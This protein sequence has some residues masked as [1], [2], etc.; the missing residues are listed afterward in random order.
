ML[1][2]G[3]K[4]FAKEVL[5]IFYQQNKVDAVAFYDGVNDD[6]GDFIYN[7]FPI[8]KNDN[9]V[10][11]FF[12]EN[13]TQFT[14]GL[15]N[16]KSRYQL[17][18]KFVSLGGEYASSISPLAVIG[19]YDNKIEEGV[20]I[21]TNTILTN[22]IKIGKGVLINLSCTIG[23]DTKI[24]DFV[25]ICP[26][27]NISGN[28]FIDKFT[29]IGTNVTI[30]PNVKIGKNVTIGAGAVVTKN[31]PDNSIAMGIPAKVVKMHKQT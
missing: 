28:C 10:K 6:I 19:N 2:I 20:N 16:P 30:L 18:R 12:N 21:M 3:A 14:I 24:E 29:F 5:E 13:G 7:I 8:L 25:E 27:V 17:Y 23:H 31:I 22:S 4:G 26:G 1:I 9:Q 11:D 15:G